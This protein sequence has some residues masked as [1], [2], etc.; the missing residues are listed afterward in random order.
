MDILGTPLWQWFWLS[1]LIE[2]ISQTTSSSLF[3]FAAAHRDSLSTCPPCTRRM[4]ELG[5][6]WTASFHNNRGGK[7]SQLLGNCMQGCWEET[8][9]N[10]L[11]LPPPPLLTSLEAKLKSCRGG[12]WNEHLS[13]D[14]TRRA[15][16]F[17]LN[18][19]IF[20]HYPS[21]VHPLSLLFL[22]AVIASIP[23][24]R[25]PCSLGTSSCV[26]GAPRR[27]LGQTT[28]ASESHGHRGITEQNHS[29]VKK[30]PLVYKTHIFIGNIPHSTVT[31][32]TSPCLVSVF[33]D[34]VS[35]VSTQPT[36]HWIHGHYCNRNNNKLFCKQNKPCAN[37]TAKC[38]SSS[39]NLRQF[40][41]FLLVQKWLVH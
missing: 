35:A 17:Q 4:Q 5:S 6:P 21:A 3:S 14:L 28:L 41:V 33:L 37:W 27:C 19:L 31:V 20:I 25:L 8:P 32:C 18:Q 10:S 7:S 39:F 40:G 29:M 11:F 13:S 9:E 36:G 12:S 22:R 2:S 15:D 24:C 1:G 23:L 30:T 34:L 16:A 38:L 26:W